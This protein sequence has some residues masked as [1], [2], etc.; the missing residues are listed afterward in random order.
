MRINLNDIGELDNFDVCIVGSGPAGITCALEIAA[1]GKRVLLLEGG[2]AEFEEQS[3]NL[4]FGNTLG[5]P[6]LD[7]TTVRLRQLGGTSGHW[8]GWCR[9]L[10]AADFEVKGG[11]QSVA[12]PIRKTDLDPYLDRAREILEVDPIGPDELLGDS[13]FSHINFVYSPPVRFAEKYGNPLTN[14]PSVFLALKANLTEI[15]TNGTA[16]TG[17]QVAGYSGVA[18]R[19]RADKYILACGGIEN[20][21]LLLWSNQKSNGQLVKNSTTLGTHWMEHPEFTVGEAILSK[22][23]GYPFDDEGIIFFSPTPALM[24]Q[25]AILS[26]GLMFH[27]TNDITAKQIVKDMACVAPTFGA[28]AFEMLN[29]KLL[30]GTRFR[31]NWEQEPRSANRVTL[32]DDLDQFGIPRTVLNWRKSEKDMKTLRVAAVRLGEYLAKENIGRVKLKPWVLGEADPPLDD[33]LAGRHHM[34]G[35]RM[36]AGPDEGVVD[37]DCRVFGQANLFIGG[38]SVFPSGGHANPTLTIVQLSLRLSEAILNGAH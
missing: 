16:V 2:D 20:S 7:L 9:Y 19:V 1:R 28:W 37:S 3:Q 24:A 21:R 26:S 35:T 10:D 34:G 27:G 23:L 17:L 13:G 11:D 33:E 5:D 36:A 32:G 18:K 12:W 8:S 38:S 22:E 6:Y 29:R 15:E 31:A 4:Y 30:C 25:E 14:S